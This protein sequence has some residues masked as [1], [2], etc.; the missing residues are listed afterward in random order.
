MVMLMMVW[1]QRWHC[2]RYFKL[3]NSTNLNGLKMPPPPL[4]SFSPEIHT[5]SGLNEPEWS[6]VPAC[7]DWMWNSQCFPALSPENSQ[8]V[9]FFSITIVITS[10]TIIRK[11]FP[12]LIINNPTVLTSSSSV[13][14]GT[15]DACYN[16]STHCA[17]CHTG[18]FFNWPPL[19]NLKY[20]KPRLGEST[21]T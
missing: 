17:T 4:Q 15:H 11:A 18:W 7:L 10:V 14:G 13:H 1:P 6:S 9:F 12:K 20:V 2:R 21:L 3:S 8:L 5:N 16:A 19:K